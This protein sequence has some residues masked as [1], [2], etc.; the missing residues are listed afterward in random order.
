MLSYILSYTTLYYI[1]ILYDMTMTMTKTM[2]DSMTIW[3]Y[4]MVTERPRSVRTVCD[5]AFQVT[6]QT[7]HFK[8]CCE[9]LRC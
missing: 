5:D 4:D 6:K 1:M 9:S 2:I 7:R 8:V 3:Q